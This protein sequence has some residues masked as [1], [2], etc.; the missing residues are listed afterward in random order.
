[1]TP[2]APDWNSRVMS[3]FTLQSGCGSLDNGAVFGRVNNKGAIWKGTQ[4]I[5]QV[6][7]QTFNLTWA[8][9]PGQ[10]ETG[11]LSFRGRRFHFGNGSEQVWSSLHG[12]WCSAYWLSKKGRT[13]FLISFPELP[14]PNPS[15]LNLIQVCDVERFKKKQREPLRADVSYLIWARLWIQR[16]LKGYSILFIAVFAA[17]GYW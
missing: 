3:C 4:A 16:I 8:F 6:K 15:S 17:P 2:R 13:V 1:M 7:L 5:R 9:A 14:P 10:Q 11:H 12:T